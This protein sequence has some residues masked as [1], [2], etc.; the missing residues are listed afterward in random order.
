MN[1]ATLT[2]LRPILPY[3]CYSNDLKA[4]ELYFLKW[5]ESLNFHRWLHLCTCIHNE[6][7]RFEKQTSTLFPSEI[8]LVF[9]QQKCLILARPQERNV[10]AINQRIGGGIEDLDPSQSAVNRPNIVDVITKSVAAPEHHHTIALNMHQVVSIRVV[11]QL[12][13][14]IDQLHR[15]GIDHTNGIHQNVHQEGSGHRHQNHQQHRRIQSILLHRLRKL[16][17]RE[18]SRYFTKFWTNLPNVGHPIDKLKKSSRIPTPPPPPITHNFT[19]VDLLD[20]PATQETIDL[21]NEDEFVPRTFSSKNLTDKVVIDLKTQ[22]ITVPTL[23][24]PDDVQNTL[25]HPNVSF[26]LIHSFVPLFSNN[27]IVVRFSYSAMTLWGW[28][29]G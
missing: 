28:K 19:S 16:K 27:N 3:L 12:L 2:E 7:G 24:T 8:F 21:I 18:V 22:T 6:I 17:F 5:R 20:E 26:S 14:V 9:V 13:R 23:E 11:D 1:F 25:F 4:S 10:L 15:K 29:N